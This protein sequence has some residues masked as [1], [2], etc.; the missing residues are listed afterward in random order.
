M[1]YKLFSWLIGFL[2][3]LVIFFASF[4]TPTLTQLDPAEK[5]N[6]VTFNAPFTLHFSHTMHRGSVED[7][8]TLLPKTEGSFRWKD[9]KT[10]E[11]IPDAP[12]NIGDEYK[13]VIKGEAKSIWMKQMG[14][15][16][17]IDYLVTGPPYVLFVD[18]P[19]GSVLTKDGVITV[20]FDRPM[21]FDGTSESDLIQAEPSLSGNVE[22]FGMS[23]FQFMPK[24]LP[25]GQTYELTIPAGLSAIDGGV[26]KEDYSWIISTPD[27]KVEKSTPETG[28]EQVATNESI[29]IY[30]GGE[31]PLE[32]IK[33][34]INALLFPSNDLDADRTRKIDGF[35]NT[36][37]TYA[38]NE[39]GE[40]QKNILVFTPTFDY[41]PDEDYLF[42]L[43]SNK[44]LPLEEDFELAFKTVRAEEYDGE[45][46]AKDGEEMEINESQS[47]A[48][49]R[50]DETME[51]FIR[52]ENPRI[53]LDEAL[54]EPAILSVCQIPSNEFIRVS[55]RHGWNN[56]ECD[57]DTVK[58]NPFQN[59][60]ELVINLNDHFNIDWVTGVYFAS[61]T[62]GEKKAVRH[63][64][65]EDSVLLMKRSDSDLFIWA[66]DVKSG[67]P[68]S[69]ME[70]E[71]LNYDGKEVAVGKTDEMG[72]FSIE[73]AF[74]AGIYV[75]AK[76]EEA[77]I[78]RWGFV[79]DRW[80][81]A[82]GKKGVS[83]EYSG[84]YVLLNQY[85]FAPGDSVKMK[86]IWRSFSDHMLSIPESTQI[87]V[88]IEDIQHNII[89]SKRIPMRRNGS[90][91]GT[92]TVPANSA[93]GYYLLSVA[94]LNHQRLASSV[95]IQVR[96]GASDLR[97]EWIEA[98]SD[99]V[100]GM[101]P[102]YIAKARY[103]NGI[104]AAKVKGNYELFRKPSGQNYQEG[105]ISFA[106]TGV[107]DVCTESCT[108]RVLVAGED[109]VF[110][111]N[112]EAK[113]LLTD[114]EDKFLSAGYDYDLQITALL[115]G[116]DP[117]TINRAFKVHQG[118]FDLGLGL[119]HALIKV[120]ETIDFNV[121]ALNHKGQMESGKKVKISLKSL[122]KGKTVFESG[123]ET[124]LRQITNSIP[125][126]PT[127]EDGVYVLRARSQDEK[128]NEVLTEQLVYVNT[129]PLLA[130]S[131]ELLLATD[132]H[133]YFVGG[134]AHLLV[135]ESTASEDNPV[136]VIVTY[137]RDGLLGYETLEL[138][139]PVTRI[140]VP[141]KESMMPYFVVNV[142]RFNRGV[143]PSFSS[144]AQK[145][146][147]ENDESQ[148]FIDLSYEPSQ[149]KPG[150][151]V[152]LKF[153]TYDYQQRPLSA[154]ITVNLLNKE[155]AL[156]ELSYESFFTNSTQV[157]E[158]ASNI[159]LQHD[160]ETMLEYN[161]ES[162]SFLFNPVQSRYFDPL[163][164]TNAGGET[165]I[166]F[167]LPEK[168]EDLYI[169]AIATKDSGQFGNHSSILR[170]NQ[171]LQ[172]QPILP[173]F[174][175]PGDQTV[176]AATVKNISDQPVQS[177]LEFL[178]PDVSARGDSARNFSLQPGQQT[179][180][181]F[182]VFIDN[183][184]EK[185]EISVEFRSGDDLSNGIVP[186]NHLKSCSKVPNSGLLADIWTGRIN[187]PKN[188]YPA[189]GNLTLTMSGGPLAFGKVQSEAL[190]GYTHESTYLLAA[191]L[192]SR[193]SF[194]PDTPTED[195][196]A[197][198]QILA[199]VLLISADENGAYRFWSEPDASPTLS[200]LALL[201]Y[202]EASLKGVHID[203]IQLNRTIDFLWRALKRGNFSSDDAVF[204]LWALG[205][206]EQYDTEM[207]LT[208]FQEKENIG[209]K[210]QAF[211]LMNLDQLIQAGQGSMSTPFATLKAEL[212]DEAIQEEELVYFDAPNETT[213]IVLYALSELGSANP[214]LEK[215]ANYL[216]F[217]EGD[218]I[219]KFNP[220]EALW[221][222]LALRSYTDQADTSGT[223]Y[224]AQV[225]FNGTLVIDQSVTGNSADEVYQTKVDAKMFNTNAIDD[226]FVKKDGTGPLYLDAHLNA[227]LDPT[228]LSRT[229]DGMIIVRKL[230]EITD[231]GER[232][233]ASTFK[234]GVNY[235]SELEVVVPN[236][237]SYVAL[238][239]SIPAG[240]KTKPG[241]MKLSE[242]FSQS[243]L[244]LGQITYYAPNLPAGVYKISTELQAVLAGNYLHLPASIQ[245]M[246]SPVTMSRTEGGIV[247]IID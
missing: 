81:I 129:N 1:K 4:G 85:V 57:T 78:N 122:D 23:A 80:S 120:N 27:L 105:A 60:A 63:F 218:L 109:F 187:L 24:D 61:I 121:I 232:I 190:E 247:Q 16:I 56:Y 208:H 112:G 48:F 58:I 131:D 69:G 46:E 167:T 236:D 211:L 19:Q 207:T 176:F 172:I 223:N 62:Q 159:T 66:L 149:P 106:F 182:T 144:S 17:T 89:V 88:T 206:N 128:R 192:L 90:F 234:K 242:P 158:A 202:S 134:R 241:M 87:T 47:E 116:G 33:P 14:Y 132:Q 153:K 101:T 216:V 42:L 239:D 26:T 162:D 152:T 114:G 110:D 55:A 102:V 94:D 166:T 212:I 49:I 165:E 194:L 5:Q 230:Y 71:V 233:P 36:E 100:A 221:T 244:G 203:S 173:S 73:Q 97:L 127:M 143:T 180:I 160:V 40:S 243:H 139:D 38:V 68:I 185:D 10:L 204:I 188:A 28:A 53:K 50:E 170:M 12:L 29:R 193:L 15:D 246:F 32:G 138:T 124:S 45:E 64:L 92:I 99:H 210:G 119:K 198:I 184:I 145:I 37:V 169:Q 178:S 51:F 8:F 115:P 199:S 108:E 155:P 54:S 70:L 235:V 79:A 157:L 205:K 103:E 123:F 9:F 189:L 18:P 245:A 196:L 222:I 43:K 227:Y 137:E 104:P 186:L 31:V 7:A 72:V 126:S 136:P 93:S 118:S 25:S 13:I 183:T 2:L 226:L 11:F 6:K 220:A 209:I 84:L 175:V 75:R 59:D 130:V 225:K 177:R 224:I 164:T 200:A 231:E 3:L 34:G 201:A 22:F 76:K 238:T 168:R 195:D 41:Q 215:M 163:I 140:T 77:G 111:S 214:L 141:I 95:P 217:Q 83:H 156:S 142:T 229:E 20:M 125:I 179:E 39:E 86:G 74:D 91:D 67:E 146:L 237:T 30:F 150:E 65:I 171:Q 117:T 113:F 154:V 174:A 197:S 151:E 133:K 96:D 181:A 147:V 240:M 82:D 98:S 148:I 21:D 191:Q 228:Q 135:N 52:G 213:A 35:F 44:D 219:Q 161:D 107:D